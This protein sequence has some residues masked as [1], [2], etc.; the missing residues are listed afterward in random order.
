VNWFSYPSGHYDAMVIAAVRAAGFVGSTTVVKGWASPQQDRFRLP[1]LQ[2]L[3]GTS[4][5]QLL[6]QIA[7]AKATTSAPPAYSGPGIA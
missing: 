7:S 2:V 3:G 4:P 6:S 5:P 1:R